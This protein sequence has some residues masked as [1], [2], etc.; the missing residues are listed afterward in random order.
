MGRQKQGRQTKKRAIRAIDSLTL[1]IGSVEGDVVG[2]LRKVRHPLQELQLAVS[3][4]A[5]PSSSACAEAPVLEAVRATLWPLVQMV[6]PANIVPPPFSPNVRQRITYTTALLTAMRDRLGALE[7][8]I[9]NKVV[10]ADADRLF[11]N[12]NTHWSGFRQNP[13]LDN[14]QQ[15]EAAAC[16]L[17]DFYW[18]VGVAP[19]EPRM[20]SMRR[21][22]GLLK[23][24]SDR[25]GE[26]DDV[27]SLARQ[28]NQAANELNRPTASEHRNWLD[29]VR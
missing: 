28:L 3:L 26:L 12:M 15:F 25:D 10:R 5:N 8:S 18:V 14:L 16:L 24:A 17:A 2:S 1:I 9:P 23:K 19:K 27:P 6:E 29:S 22:C 11:E 4:L 20:K 7:A 13:T 21:L